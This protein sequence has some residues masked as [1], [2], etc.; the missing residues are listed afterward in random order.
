VEGSGESQTRDTPGNRPS[1]YRYMWGFRNTTS[2]RVREMRFESRSVHL[3]Q[4]ARG[5]RNANE[6]SRPPPPNG[7]KRG[8]AERAISQNGL[9]F[10]D[11][12]HFRFSFNLAELSRRIFPALFFSSCFF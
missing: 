3:F 4:D 5:F 12:I 11:Q 2:T 9:H 10:S 1:S 8:I 6:A 7:A